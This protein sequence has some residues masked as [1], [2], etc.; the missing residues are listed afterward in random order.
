MSQSSSFNNDRQSMNYSLFDSLAMDSPIA[1][2]RNFSRFSKL[3]G[4]FH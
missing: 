3:A 1:Y 4:M 2:Q